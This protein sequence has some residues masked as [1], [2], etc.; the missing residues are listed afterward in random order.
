MDAFE[1]RQVLRWCG[2]QAFSDNAHSIIENAVNEASM[3]TTTPNWYAVLS[4]G[5][6][7]GKSRDVQCLGTCISSGSRKSPQQ[8]DS[9]REIF[10]QSL[11]VVMENER[12]V[13]AY[14]K[15]RWDWTEWQ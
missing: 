1:D 6:D 9:G 2:M 5:V 4:S 8:R 14:P 10:A 3:R 12:P 7:Q 13:Q 15:I 11:E